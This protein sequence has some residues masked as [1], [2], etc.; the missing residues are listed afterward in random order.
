MAF[1][2]WTGWWRIILRVD[3]YH[4]TR[5][6]VEQALPAIAEKLLA[7]GERLSVVAEDAALLDRIDQALWTFRADSFVPHG[8][9]QDQPV[10]LGEQAVAA[11]PHVAFA[12]GI[13]REDAL[14][15]QRT[16]YFFA[17]DRIDDARAA[18]RQLATREDAE[19]HYWKQTE[20]RWVEGP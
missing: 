18:W 4:L 7:N 17:E 2:C 16:F 5:T 3:F 6:P 12:D 10:T 19:R 20:G 15:P 13:W 9:D 8:R 11:C 1:A 14:A